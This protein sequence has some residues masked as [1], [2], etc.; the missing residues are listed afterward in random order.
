MT[1]AETNRVLL[2]E[3]NLIEDTLAKGDAEICENCGNVFRIEFL[4]AGDDYND[5]GHRYCPYCGLLTNEC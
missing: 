3:D 2:P 4:K 1:T 5:F